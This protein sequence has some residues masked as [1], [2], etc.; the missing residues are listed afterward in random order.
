[1]QTFKNRVTPFS[2]AKRLSAVATCFLLAVAASSAGAADIT[3][4]ITLRGE[5]DVPGATAA[6]HCGDLWA[7]G[8]YA[9]I[10]SDRLG[11]GIAIFDISNPTNPQFVTEYE[12]NEME[13]VEVYNGVGFFGSDVNDPT[14]APRTG[15][16][17]VNLS[18]P[19]NPT[20]ITRISTAL[21]PQAHDKV[22]T[23][24]VSDGFLYTTDNATEVIKVFNVSNPASP[25][26]V[27]SINL[28]I[29]G[30]MAS[31]EVMVQNG[32]MYVASKNNSDSVNGWTHIY[33]VSNVATTGP[34]L[35]KA[36]NTGGGT[37]T[38]MPS[39]DGNILV[40]SQE[41]PNGEVRIYDI[42]AIDQPND[43]D[44]PTLLKTITRSTLGI[45]AHSPHHSH[46]HG[47]LLFL[48]WY[49][50]GLIVLNMADPANPAWV[51]AFD[52]YPGTSTLFNGNWG[53]FHGLGLDKMLI[54]DRNRGLLIVDATG[55]APNGD[56]N[57]DGM[58][59]GADLLAWQRNVGAASA[60]LAQ[61][62]AN[63]DRLISG[64]DL[65]YIRQ[66]FGQTTGGHHHALPVPEAA[67]LW[68]GL[69]AV[70]SVAAAS[71][72]QLM[73]RRKMA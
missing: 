33:D 20:L 19:R 11:G 23:L 38:S 71:R 45:E 28:N 68:L 43:P 55:V 47:D 25:Q 35:L 59:D 66:Q 32:R 48:S 13:D 42:S 1:V 2:A 54:S 5:A 56:V 57:S 31:H 73:R 52:T 60:T 4:N 39:E 18:N 65:A 70:A 69:F 29:P 21:F 67:G 34:A 62:D 22:H 61:G 7:E 6:R 24:S 8:N 50:A 12:G 44:S 27:S 36:F 9:Y 64:A 16:D 17:I 46:M 72:G 53:A 15:V 26:F 41:R 10:G 51:G 40:V 58:V 63:R 30:T 3:F 14:Q 37:H 49:E